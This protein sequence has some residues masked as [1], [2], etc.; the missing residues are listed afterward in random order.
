M[1]AVT[2]DKIRWKKNNNNI[3]K[4]SRIVCTN[5]ILFHIWIQRNRNTNTPNNNYFWSTITTT[6][7]EWKI[8]KITPRI[9]YY[10][11]THL[12]HCN[13]H[14][15]SHTQAQAYVEC[16]MISLLALDSSID[17][18]H[19]HI[20]MNKSIKNE[21][22][23]KWTVQVLKQRFNYVHMKWVVREWCFCSRV[24]L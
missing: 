8:C 14:N 15:V 22:T 16:E 11:C 19:R 3:E 17:D 4:R 7:T 1:L 20:E 12:L 2:N 21:K 10:I 18:R 5:Y 24:C 6:T 9:T 23:I 13:L